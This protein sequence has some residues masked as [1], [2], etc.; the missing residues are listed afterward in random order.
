MRNG[1]GIWNVR[2]MPRRQIWCADMPPISAS[3]KR[4]EPLVG[5]IAPAIRLKVVL[6]PD[7]LGPMR[8]R[9][10]P[11]R[12]SKET[13]LTARKPPKRFDRPATASIYARMA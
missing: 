1:R 4:I 11:S 3:A 5:R 8:P 9:I 12:T 7:P 10:S 2:A 6:L 13:W